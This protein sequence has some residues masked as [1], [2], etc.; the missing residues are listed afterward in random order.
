M[1][2]VWQ[3]GMLRVR[4]ASGVM[5]YQGRSVSLNRKEA[6]LMTALT[7]KP[8]K[9]IP[10]QELIHQI[11]QNPSSDRTASLNVYISRLRKKLA[12]LTPT[13]ILTSIPQGGYVLNAEND[14]EA[15]T[16]WGPQSAPVG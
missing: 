4:P 5:E 14:P 6:Q 3:V 12:E 1:D 2:P 13:V 8:G 15:R 10:R 16:G 11:W 9:L 7:R